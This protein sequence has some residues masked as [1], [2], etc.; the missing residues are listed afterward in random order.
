MAWIAP[1]SKLKGSENTLKRVHPPSKM[2]Q[3]ML[4]EKHK[5]YIAT[6]GEGDGC[7]EYKMHV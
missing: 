3:Y 4:L 5:T 6:G 1:E 2:S 7:V